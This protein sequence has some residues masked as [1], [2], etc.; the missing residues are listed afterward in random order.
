MRV[1]ALN[2]GLMKTDTHA[3]CSYLALHITVSYCVFPHVSTH[4]GS[5]S[6]DKV[7]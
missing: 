5:T 4:K 3:Q 6:G 2:V 7:K 1:D